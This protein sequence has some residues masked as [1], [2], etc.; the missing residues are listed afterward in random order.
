M[1]DI[2]LPKSQ[3]LWLMYYDSTHKLQYVIA[4]DLQRTKYILYKVSEDYSLK[5]VRTS[6]KP[7][8][9]ECGYE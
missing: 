1:N 6:V 3:T 7:T 9:K 4:S 8:F 2:K 5:K